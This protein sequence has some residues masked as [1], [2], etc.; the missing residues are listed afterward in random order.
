MIQVPPH[1]FVGKPDPMEH[2][3]VVTPELR[4]WAADAAVQ[5][6]AAGWPVPADLDRLCAGETLTRNRWWWLL[7][8]VLRPQPPCPF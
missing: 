5:L 8:S 2:E 7:N 4:A 3:L 1:D 6:A